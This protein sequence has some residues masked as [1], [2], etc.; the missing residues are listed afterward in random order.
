MHRA[1][2]IS[3]YIRVSLF[4]VFGESFPTTMA[5]EPEKAWSSALLDCFEDMN[6]WFSLRRR[7]SVL[8]LSVVLLNG[9]PFTTTM[10]LGEPALTENLLTEQRDR[11]SGNES[12]GKSR[13]EISLLVFRIEEENRPVQNVL[14]FQEHPSSRGLLRAEA[15]QA[16]LR[17]PD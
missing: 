1:E 7:S 12:E 9:E 3:S 4:T 2:E 5:G 14:H 6:T 16:Q 10:K 8:F 11:E 17:Q 13:D 15:V